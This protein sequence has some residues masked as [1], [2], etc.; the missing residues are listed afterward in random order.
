MPKPFKQYERQQRLLFA[1]DEF[2][3]GIYFTNALIPPGSVRALVN[4]D[5]KDQGLKLSPRPSIKV[6][7]TQELNDFPE[8]LD[9]I[10][11]GKKCYQEDGQEYN[12]VILGGHEELSNISNS[13]YEGPLWVSTDGQTESLSSTTFVKPQQAKIHDL[14]LEEPT[15]VARQVGTFAYYDQYYYINHEEGLKYTAFED[16]VYKENSL[17]PKSITPKEAVMWGY[18]MLRAEPYDFENKHYEG[19]VQILGVLP[20]D[21]NNTSELLMTPKVNDDLLFK[22]FYEGDENET[23]TVKWEWKEPTS[24][25]WNTIKE[26]EVDLDGLPEITADFSPSTREAMIRVSF[27]DD[28]DYPVKV[29]S[30]GFDFS[31]ERH[32]STANIDPVNYDLNKATGLVYWEKAKALILYGLEKNPNILFRSEPNEPEYF[33]YP[34]NTEIFDEPIIH[35]VPLLDDLIIFTAS[36]IHL[37]ALTNEGHI[38]TETIQSGLQIEPWDVH[39]IT[40]VRN[41]IFFKSGNY[42]YMVVP[43]SGSNTG[44]LTIA[45]ISRSIEFFLDYFTTSVKEVLYKL[46]QFE[47][48][49]KLIHYYNFL[50]FEDIHNVYVFKIDD[51]YLNFSLL[52][53]SVERTWRIYIYESPSPYL[54][55]TEDATQK[56]TLMA[57]NS[58][59]VQFLNY[60]EQSVEDDYVGGPEKFL[61]YQLLDTGSRE[62]DSNF[63]KRYREVQF[64]INKISE[65]NLSFHSEFSLDERPRKFLYRYNTHHNTDS[66]DPDYGL[67][68]VVEELVD[69]SVL[70]NITRLAEDEDDDNCWE[71]DFSTFPD[72]SIWKIRVAV[73]GKGYSPK[74]V[75]LSKNQLKYELLN[76]SWVFRP[77]Y[78]R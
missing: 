20:Y 24:S 38:I 31:K 32:G 68:T 66:S 60:D 69:P 47:D 27:Y 5:L 43:K 57:L 46:Y 26:E 64:K 21:P 18:N 73:S 75:L 58:D 71:L 23:Y 49:L 67:L 14:K 34:I 12:Q 15:S 33:P 41:M 29:M 53:N 10:C 45:P 39:L 70:P 76:I 72:V 48:D 37:M 3:K 11:A 50:D 44:E 62:Q 1:E 30:V 74:L 28:E 35:A 63:K 55:F 9:T 4:Y 77:L 19:S 17:E 61:N 51:V 42:Y 16:G 6:S 25:A 78:A 56:G 2:S 40:S 65:E 13:L 52:Y 7:Y 59:G 36:K 54:P 8:D 22:C